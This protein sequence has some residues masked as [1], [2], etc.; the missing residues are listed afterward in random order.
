MLQIYIGYKSKVSVDRLPGV[1]SMTQKLT[2][3]RVPLVGILS[4]NEQLTVD[5]V[6]GAL[7]AGQ[8]S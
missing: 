7:P 6:P 4:T 8:N 3:D 2:E 1:L 5:S